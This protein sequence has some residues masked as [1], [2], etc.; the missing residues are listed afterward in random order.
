MNY[1][2]IRR[3]AYT[4]AGTVG[5][6]VRTDTENGSLMGLADTRIRRDAKT[7]FSPSTRPQD[8]FSS[9][10][11]S[12]RLL[13]SRRIPFYRRPRRRFILIPFCNASP[14]T[15]RKSFLRQ[16]LKGLKARRN[17]ST[18]S[19]VHYHFPFCCPP[20][21]ILSLARTKTHHS[22]SP[23]CLS[24]CATNAVIYCLCSVVCCTFSYD[25]TPTRFSYI[26]IYIYYLSEHF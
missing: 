19:Y 6:G 20:Y 7:F 1:Y 23:A 17:D 3:R 14:G 2:G 10:V 18:L 13:S 12:L 21:T 25:S 26:Y 5:V 15:A 8:N 9:Q 16:K 11:S 24:R 4:P 22:I